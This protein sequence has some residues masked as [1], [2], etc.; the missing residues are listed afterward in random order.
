ML[1]SY[2]SWLNGGK[3]WFVSPCLPVG[4]DRDQPRTR[5]AEPHCNR[6][7]LEVPL[8]LP[9]HQILEDLVTSEWERTLRPA[10]FRLAQALRAA[11]R[12]RGHHRR[13]RRRTPSPPLPLPPPREDPRPTRPDRNRRQHR[14]AQP[15]RT[16]RLRLPT[17][18][19]YG[20]PAV[21]RCR[22]PN[23]AR[24]RGAKENDLTAQDSRQSPSLVRRRR[25]TREAR[26][27]RLG[28]VLPSDDGSVA[29]RSIAAGRLALHIV[30]TC[31]CPARHGY[32]ALERR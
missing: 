4:P 12:H 17:P 20:L 16:H 25:R 23:P 9:V 13:V 19:A 5:G 24:S 28:G 31:I 8:V 11:Q 3:Q 7:G 32:S 30:T 10:G 26:W 22:R 1:F 15:A 29:G 14:T 18:A 21:P 2:P 6:I 27:S